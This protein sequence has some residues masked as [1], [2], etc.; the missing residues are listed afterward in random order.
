MVVAT[1]VALELVVC[2]LGFEKA[3][4]PSV[5]STGSL[6]GVV[7]RRVMMEEGEE[8]VSE[9]GDVEKKERE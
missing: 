6:P 2:L 8:T 3:F 9:R 7:E 5:P 4:K 1:E